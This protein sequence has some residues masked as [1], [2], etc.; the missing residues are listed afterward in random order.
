[1]AL[2]DLLGVGGVGAA[3][4]VAAWH[5]RTGLSMLSRVGMWVRVGVG[6]SLLLGLLLATGVID[7]AVHVDKLAAVGGLV[8]ELLGDILEFAGLELL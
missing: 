7:L 3:V 6:L 8:A 5:A 4:L 1:M 2:L